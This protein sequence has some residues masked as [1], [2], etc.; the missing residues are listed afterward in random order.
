MGWGALGHW[1]ARVCLFVYLRVRPRLKMMLTH[2]GTGP[3]PAPDVHNPQPV[4]L[5][6]PVSGGDPRDRALPSGPSAAGGPPKR[7][8]QDPRSHT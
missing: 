2:P 7:T 3:S 8:S 4:H 6:G 5:K 1:D